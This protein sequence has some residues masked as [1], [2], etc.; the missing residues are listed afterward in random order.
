MASWDAATQDRYA[1]E[2][3]RPSR[4]LIA[5][6]VG[7]PPR[8]IVDLGCGSGL[9]TQAL[10]QSFR[11]AERGDAVRLS[12]AVSGGDAGAWLRER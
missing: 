1:A 8:R 12:P 10:A 4:D 5:R 7:P 3:E 11:L 9:S 6:L 2:R